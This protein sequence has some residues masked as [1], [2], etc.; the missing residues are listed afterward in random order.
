MSVNVAVASTPPVTEPLTWQQICERY[1]DQWVCLVDFDDIKD[2]DLEF[3][4]A[5]VI[6]AGSTRRAPYDQARPW[7]AG[8]EEVGHFFTGPIRALPPRFL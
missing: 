6:G 1:P 2:T 8:Y 4:T 7:L 5:R 3:R